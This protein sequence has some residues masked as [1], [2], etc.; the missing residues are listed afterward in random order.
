MLL[1]RII[2]HVSTQN[3]TAVALDFAI[4]VVGVFMGIQLGNWNQER[5]DRVEEAIFLRTL[6]QDVLELERITD[7][8][9]DLRVAQL[10][11][12]ASVAAV[13]QGRESWRELTN[14]ECG[15]IAGSHIVGILP[16]E[17]P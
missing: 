6:Q 11:D 10:S 2:T 9:I 4:V 5:H 16:T 15:S 13:L 14:D 1:R 17:L 12:I 3:W 8:L 7:R